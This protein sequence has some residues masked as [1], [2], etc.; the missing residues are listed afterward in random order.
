MWIYTLILTLTP[1]LT[2]TLTLTLTG[3]PVADPAARCSVELRP[4]GGHPSGGYEVTILGSGFDEFDANA[5][6][7]R[8]TLA[9]RPTPTVPH[10]AS[11]ICSLVQPCCSLVQ[12]CAT[13]CSLVA[14]NSTHANQAQRLQPHICMYIEAASCI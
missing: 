5:S 1:T 13:L 9:P 4:V 12:P 2:P 3:E 8:A 6:T 14:A 10:T 7:V 11:A